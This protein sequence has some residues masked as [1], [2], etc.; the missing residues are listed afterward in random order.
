MNA[1]LH[2]LDG[3]FVEALGWTLL[4]SLWQGA[5]VMLILALIL[6]F[7]QGHSAHIRYG[8]SIAALILMILWS[9]TTFINYYTHSTQAEAVIY[10]YPEAKHSVSPDV[11]T[12]WVFSEASAFSGSVIN[13]EVLRQKLESFMQTSSPFI[14]AFWLFGSLLFF[15]KWLGGLMYIHRIRPRGIVSSSYGWQQKLNRLARRIGILKP[16]RLLESMRVHSPMVIGLLK[17]IILLPVGMLTGMTSEQIET[18]LIHELA[19]IRRHDYF[20]NLVQSILEVIYFYHPAY[21][22]ISAKIQQ[23]REHCCDDIAVAVCGD[24]MLYARALTEVQAMQ[25]QPAPGLALG[26]GGRKNQ[27]MGRIK[28]LLTPVQE[29]ANMGAKVILSFILLLSIWSFAWVEDISNQAPQ[30]EK[31]WPVILPTLPHEDPVLAFIPSQSFAFEFEFQTQQPSLAVEQFLQFMIASVDNTRPYIYRFSSPTPELAAL[32]ELLEIAWTDVQARQ[33]YQ[34]SLEL[35][36]ENIAQEKKM[37]QKIAQELKLL[38]VSIQNPAFH[39]Y[40]E[41]IQLQRYRMDFGTKPDFSMK[42]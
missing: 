10:E 40:Q 28:R 1:I 13:I 11:P 2:T 5:V 41:I 12:A 33:A 23:E 20:I 30:P 34:Q 17:P 27:L 16:I 19:H 25:L 22:W 29:R 26:V 36:K 38:E 18:I 42:F 35:W 37:T 3:S 9:G 39:K 24:A 31:V 14:A 8:F 15:L 7:T 21:W 4:H 6:G 32:P